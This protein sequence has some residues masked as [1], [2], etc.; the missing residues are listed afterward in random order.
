MPPDVLPW[1]V[2]ALLGLAV[3]VLVLLTRLVQRLEAIERRLGSSEQ[4]ATIA[5]AVQEL[6]RAHAELDVRRVEHVL[7]DI[8]DG[9]RRVEDRLIGALES[10]GGRPVSASALE[11]VHQALQSTL[12]ER[13]VTRLL[14]LG[15]E[16]IQFVTPVS[17]VQKLSAADGEVAVEARRDGA[18]CKGRVLVKNGAI[19]DL[20]LQSAYSIFP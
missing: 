20:Q 1:L 15:Y 11:P 8:R 13:I 14:A 18:A 6:A 9:Q 19:A 7:I 3:G 17:E 16:R 5:S 12:P 4:V 2:L 10:Q